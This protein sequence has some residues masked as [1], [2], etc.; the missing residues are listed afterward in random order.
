[1]D[2]NCVVK[3][4]RQ[5]AKSF[6]IPCTIYRL[7]PDNMARIKGLS[8]HKKRCWLKVELS[9]LNNLIKKKLHRCT[10]Q[11]G[12]QLSLD[13]VMLMTKNSYNY[14]LWPIIALNYF[15][16]PFIL[17]II[18]NKMNFKLTVLWKLCSNIVFSSLI[19]IFLRL[20]SFHNCSLHQTYA[21]SSLLKSSTFLYCKM[22]TESL[23]TMCNIFCMI[24]ME[25]W[26]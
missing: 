25:K 13:L 6:L 23:K 8:S 26:I 22:W 21:Y 15:F 2:L 19:D 24:T 17:T 7:L 1:M 4:T 20:Y 12:F 14:Q 11:L 16:F 9:N 18:V 10:L 3:A 5:R